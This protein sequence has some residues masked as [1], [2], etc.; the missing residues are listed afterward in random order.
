M[1]SAGQEMLDNCRRATQRLG[2]NVAV[3][4]GAGFTRDIL[5]IEVSMRD[6]RSRMQRDRFIVRTD[7]PPEHIRMQFERAL[8][9]ITGLVFTSALSE[10]ERDGVP[11]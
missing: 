2:L 1:N 11:T 8:K 3:S 6:F 9:S 10:S 7:A 5:I 4:L